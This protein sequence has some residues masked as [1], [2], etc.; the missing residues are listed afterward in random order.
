MLQSM[1]QQRVRHDWV[2]EQQHSQLAETPLLGLPC[3]SLV[4]VLFPDLTSAGGHDMMNNAGLHDLMR[5][6]HHEVI[7]AKIHSGFSYPSP[8][9]SDLLLNKEKERTD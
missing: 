6:G 8:S 9:L 3:N 7:Q 2:T 4:W 5:Q 1:G